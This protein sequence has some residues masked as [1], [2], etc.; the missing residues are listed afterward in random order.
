MGYSTE[1]IRGGK[2]RRQVEMSEEKEG[3][4]VDGL[5]DSSSKENRSDTG[6]YEQ[7]KSREKI[8]TEKD[9]GGDEIRLMVLD[10]IDTVETN[11]SKLTS[12]VEQV[13]KH[14]IPLV[15]LLFGTACCQMMPTH[16][17]LLLDDCTSAITMIRQYCVRLEQ[18][19]QDKSKSYIFPLLACIYY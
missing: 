5:Y 7:I 9:N 8:M 19:L 10:Q 12:T 4:L 1:Y 15:L 3:L 13:R 11:V 17:S 14:F 16:A 18:I 6:A 2:R